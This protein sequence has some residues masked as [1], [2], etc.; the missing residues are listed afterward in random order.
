M[1]LKRYPSLELRASSSEHLL[2]R[3][4]GIIMFLKVE[5]QKAEGQKASRFYPPPLILR[6]QVHARARYFSRNS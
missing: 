5:G 6:I 3:F 2:N 1:S 4:Y